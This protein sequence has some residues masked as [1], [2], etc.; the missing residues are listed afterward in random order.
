MTR[1]IP[2][3]FPEGVAAPDAAHAFIESRDGRLCAIDLETGRDRWCVNVAARPRLVAGRHLI[4]YDRQGSREN[5]LKFIALDIE[6]HGASMQQ[7]DPVVLDDW[8]VV[9]DP[10][11]EFQTALWADNGDVVIEWHAKS[12]YAGG[13]PA[14]MHIQAAARREARGRTRLNLETGRATSEPVVAADP[15]AGQSGSGA[16]TIPDEAARLVPADGQSAAVI[17]PRLFY[18][19]EPARPSEGGP[20]LVSV[21]VQSGRTLWERTLPPRPQARPAARR[22]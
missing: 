14:P 1:A 20:R 11:L 17:G 21:D 2:V 22:M 10:E 7:L 9:D 8:I 15:I 12:Q 6:R 19:V 18:L 16:A 13:A 5:V 4:A 3:P